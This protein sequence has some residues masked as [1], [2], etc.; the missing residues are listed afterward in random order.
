MKCI[1][2]GWMEE[3]RT[4]YFSNQ[5]DLYID[6]L[7]KINRNF[8]SILEV[9]PGNGSF[10]SMVMD[11]YDVSS[12]VFLD[13]PTGLSGLKS[14]FGEKAEYVSCFDYKTLF[15]K[16]FDIV[17]SNVCIPE[18]PK[19]YR[20]DLLSNILPNSNSAMIIGQLEGPWDVDKN[21]KEFLLSLFERLYEN[22]EVE[23]TSYAEC[24]SVVGYNE[25]NNTNR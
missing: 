19:E 14:S 12:Y 3:G 24:Y 6:Q 1:V 13:I 15:Q 4:G 23:K 9:G 5:N 21:Y 22:V 17:I 11:K 18:T 7:S 2:P 8:S 16:K 20:E 10:A 25:A